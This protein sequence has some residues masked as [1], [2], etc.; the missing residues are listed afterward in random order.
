MKRV[1]AALSLAAALVLPTAAQSQFGPPEL[2][3][4]ARKEGKLFFYSANVAESERRC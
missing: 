3:E 2:I 4:A 1:L